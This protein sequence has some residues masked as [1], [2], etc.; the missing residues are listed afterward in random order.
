M[1]MTRLVVGFAL[2]GHDYLCF[3]NGALVVML[4]VLFAW[5]VTRS[6]KLW[7]VFGIQ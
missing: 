7:Q 5:T 6:I 4:G 1:L 2:L 3:I